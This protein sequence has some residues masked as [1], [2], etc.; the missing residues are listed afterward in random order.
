MR[1]RFLSCG[2]D[3]FRCRLASATLFSADLRLFWAAI[4]S[5]NSFEWLNMSS[6]SFFGASCQAARLKSDRFFGGGATL[7]V[8][9]VIV[10]VAA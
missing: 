2:S 6:L 4:M 8:V 3:A 10:I 7:V 5:G 1:R 9:S